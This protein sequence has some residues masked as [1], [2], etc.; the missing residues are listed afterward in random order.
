MKLLVAPHADDETLFAAYVQLAFSP[1]VVVCL[2]GR[3]ARHL[4]RNAVRESESLAACNVLGTRVGFVPSPCDPP[5]WPLVEEVL[6]GWGDPQRVFAPLPEPGGHR[7]HNQIGNLAH[8]L[9]PDRTTFYATYRDLEKSTTGTPIEVQ[10]GWFA[11]KAAALSCYRSQHS[12]P[13]T[14]FHFHRDQTEYL[15]DTLVDVP[16]LKLNLGAGPNGMPDFANFDPTYKGEYRWQFPEPI[17]F[18]DGQVDAITVSHV[19]M[20]V[21]H[22]D[23]PACFAEMARVLAPHGVVRITE[24]DIGGEGSSRQQIRPGAAVATTPALVMD[25][26]RDA[27]LYAERVTARVSAW[28]D[29]SLVQTNY[30]DEPDVFHVEGWRV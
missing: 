20:Y 8:S 2:Q 14:A 30:G 17:P 7:Q 23:W 25:A 29:M 1:E 27:G 6:R 18:P 22:E 16:N 11:K 13:D 10:D 15:S 26:L 12:K 3:R 24:D 4:P 28:H 19:L 21:P 5:D 9:W